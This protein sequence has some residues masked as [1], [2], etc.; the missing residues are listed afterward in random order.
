[1][2][3]DFALFIKMALASLIKKQFLKVAQEIRVNRCESVAKSA[4]GGGAA[5]KVLSCPP[6]FHHI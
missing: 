2:T 3:F 1:M 6:P 4:A 5:N